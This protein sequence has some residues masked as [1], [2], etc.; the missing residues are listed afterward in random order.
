MGSESDER[1]VILGVD[2][3]TTSTVCV[4]MPLLLFSEF[5][6]PL[7]VLG[8]SVAGCSNFNSVG[9]DVARETLEKVMAEALLDAGVKRSA[10]KAVCLGLSGVNHPT[11]QEKILGWLSGYGIAAQA[12]IA[13]M[14]AHDG[15]G[16]QT[17]LSSCILQ[18]L[19]LSSPDEL[20]G[21]TYADPSWARIA[22]LVPVVVSCAEDGDQ[23]AD[24][25]LHNAVQE[26]A[27]SVKAV[28]QRLRL[29]GEDGKGSFPVVMVGGVLGAN[30]KWNIGNEVTNSILKT[31]PGACVIRPKVEPAVGAALLALNFLMKETVANGHS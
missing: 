29:A 26:L 1:E 27:I 20:I 15:R 21:W 19:G 4:C 23:L 18:S 14:R 9:E 24:E 2:G 13:V 7:P 11:D 8:R 17:M 22:A 12:L 25:I 6:D 5:P 16:P 3:G 31:Y 30:N 10:V 28:V